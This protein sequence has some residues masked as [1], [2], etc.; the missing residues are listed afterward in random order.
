[1]DNGERRTFVLPGHGL[2]CGKC[3]AT[4]PAVDR[5]RASEGFILRERR[6][7]ECGELSVTSE[8]V[9]DTRP[10]RGRKITIRRDEY[11]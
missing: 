3:G 5:T 9:I 11:L 4:L 10:I 2:K 1:M 7:V 8:R 6:C